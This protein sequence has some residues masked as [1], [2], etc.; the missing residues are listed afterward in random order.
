[1]LGGGN[2]NGGMAV[3]R[4]R[5]GKLRLESLTPEQLCRVLVDCVDGCALFIV[6]LEGRVASWNSGAARIFGYGAKEAIGRP[7]ESFFCEEDRA[8][9]T[10]ENILR[11]A[12]NDERSEWEGWR[13]HKDGRRLWTAATTVAPHIDRA[14]EPATVAVDGA[15]VAACGG[16]QNFAK[17]RKPRFPE[18]R[19]DPPGPG[20][21]P[22]VL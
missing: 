17:A 10:P 3:N 16:R 7:F 9:G 20:K 15:Q 1:V 19:F 5:K 13:V 18:I 12:A 14:A 11:L 22:T 21:R 4:D 8:T 6:D 2:F